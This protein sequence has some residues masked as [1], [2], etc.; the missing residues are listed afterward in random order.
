MVS[1]SYEV[2]WTRLLGHILGGSVYAFATMLATFLVGIALGS[3]VAS[4]LATARD[5]AAGI[6]AL[7]QLGA[8]LLS[9]AA[10]SAL[11][12]LPLLAAR[13]G[14]GAAASATAANVALSSVALLPAALCIGATFPL[15]VRILARHEAEA[16]PASAR[17]FAWNTLGAIV[18]S[19]GAGFWWIPALG[20]AGTLTAAVAANLSLAAA[21]CFLIPRT[22]ARQPS[23]WSP[24]RRRGWC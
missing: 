13:I 10:F 7:A 2:L 5:R 6:F 19:V 4:R 21:A 8:A 24:P 9:Y 20:Y 11:D 18:G 3:A 1:F 14:A 22:E 16:G 12:A 17:V 15:A 23:S